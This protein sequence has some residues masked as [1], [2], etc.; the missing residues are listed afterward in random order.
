MHS[1]SGAL[2]ARGSRE[3]CL[4]LFAK[5]EHAT[6]TRT[7]PAPMSE[8]SLAL[9]R[10][11]DLDLVRSTR[12][13]NA[14]LLATLVGR[15]GFFRILNQPAQDLQPS[16]LVLETDDP[17]GLRQFLA[18]HEIYCPIH[19][20]PSELLPGTQRW[21]TRYISLPIDHRYGAQDMQRTATTVQTFFP[22]KWRGS[23]S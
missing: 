23:A 9:L 5:A 17:T 3:Y 4:A 8:G 15:S 20:P 22:Q 1:K 7:Q 13:T 12:Q 19:W 6:Q 2:A 11:L 21:P 14:T 10:H 16:H 18:G